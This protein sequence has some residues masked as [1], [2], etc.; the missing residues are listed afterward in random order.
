MRHM[1]IIFLMMIG[2]FINLNGCSNREKDL[3]LK[4]DAY[5]KTGEYIKALEL[6]NQKIEETPSFLFA[7]QLKIE[8]LLESNNIRPALDEYDKFVKLNEDH[9]PYLIEKVLTDKNIYTHEMVE[10]FFAHEYNTKSDVKDIIVD[11][12][13]KAAKAKH[14]PDSPESRARVFDGLGY[15][16]S[17]RVIPVLVDAAI[18]EN[19]EIMDRLT[20]ISAIVRI[21]GQNA[22]SGLLP[23]LKVP[24]KN[25][26][27]AAA[28]GFFALGNFDGRDIVLS[29]ALGMLS[30]ESYDKHVDG[31]KQLG[32]L[33]ESKEA[34]RVLLDTLHAIVSIRKVTHRWR[35]KLLDATVSSL[36]KLGRPPE[37]INDLLVVIEDFPGSF[38]TYT[39]ILNSSINYL[40]DVEKS[41]SEINLI[42]EALVEFIRE[43]TIGSCRSMADRGATLVAYRTLQSIDSQTANLLFQQFPKWELNQRGIY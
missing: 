40:R 9:S 11:I 25:I 30:D 31:A 42:V 33:G 28:R 6:L 32:E 27:V 17:E 23:L 24:D 38:D 37:A 4:V 41:E 14:Q 7:R 29:N 21:G 16:K 12:L 13:L 35:T 5:R 19:E 10:Y 43:Y 3:Q 22:I 34:T 26:S 15:T 8:L 20:A 1:V 39:N 18:N 36:I 2:C